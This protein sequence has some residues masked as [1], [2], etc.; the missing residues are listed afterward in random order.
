MTSATVRPSR[1]TAERRGEGRSLIFFASVLLMVVGFFYLIDGIAAI[2]DSHF[3]IVNAHYVI[4]DLR[5]WGWTVLILGALQIAVAFGV[6]AGNQVACWT[7]RVSPWCSPSSRTRCGR[8][9]SVTG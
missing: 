5:T 9:S 6:L 1:G 3:F 7:P 2:A 8:R 4:G